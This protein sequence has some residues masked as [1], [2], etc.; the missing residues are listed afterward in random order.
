MPCLHYGSVCLLK[1]ITKLLA[2][3]IVTVIWS[4]ENV[5]RLLP[6]VPLKDMCKLHAMQ[7]SAELAADAQS[8]YRYSTG[9]CTSMVQCIFKIMRIGAHGVPF[10]L[11]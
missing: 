3:L 1:I 2:S 9:S 7:L 5:K 6:F 11:F 4:E 8:K 10:M